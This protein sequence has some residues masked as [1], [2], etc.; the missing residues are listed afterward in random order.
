M[1]PDLDAVLVAFRY[2]NAYLRPMVTTIYCDDAGFTGDNLLNP[3]QPFFA[4]AAT[5]V[6]PS[7]ANGLVAELRSRFAIGTAELKGKDLYRRDCAPKLIA[8][9]TSLLGGRTTIALNHKLYA[10]SCK[11][12]EYIYEPVL[13]ENSRFFYDR[14]V[15]DYVAMVL[16]AYLQRGD[17]TAARLTERFEAIM[18]RQSGAPALY[19][20]P[21]AQD[22]SDLAIEPILRF[23]EANREQA[24]AELDDLADDTGRIKFVL[25]LSLSS[26]QSVLTTS[27]ERYGEIDVVMDESRPL[28]AFSD[29]FNSF[30]S[31]T[32][33]AYFEF[34][35]RRQ[36]LTF[37]LH[38]ELRFGSSKA[39][40]GLQL[41]D[42]FASFAALAAR[43]RDTPRGRAILEHLLPLLDE[44]ALFPKYEMLDLSRK[45]MM[46]TMCLVAELTRRAEARLSLLDGIEAYAGFIARRLDSDPPDFRAAGA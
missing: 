2:S 38:R 31:R 37:H 45:E 20:D 12:Y 13:A 16:F 5:A 8:W 18:R 36:P 46:A 30:V 7:Q 42:I 10:L 4:Y 11:F 3:D 32:E 43:D 34:R 28:E 22:Q 29:F 41:A 24:M 25:D 26:A 40:A 44:G 9:L 19:F 33:T 17:Q 23:A 1:R 14:G 21:T 35:G 6:E 39:D 15:H 27:G